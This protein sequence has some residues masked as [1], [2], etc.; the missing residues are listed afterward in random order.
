[1]DS[2][3]TIFS[4]SSYLDNENPF[5]QDQENK[6]VSGNDFLFINALLVLPEA[7]PL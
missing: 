6:E 2:G 1:M 5:N 3:N 4:L 7:F